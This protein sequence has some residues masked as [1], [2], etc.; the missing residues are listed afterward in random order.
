MNGITAT[1]AAAAD[2][3]DV[4]KPAASDI[5]GEISL[6]NDEVRDIPCDIL[7]LS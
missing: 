5:S 4:S 7:L 1:D 2:D 3:D 6:S